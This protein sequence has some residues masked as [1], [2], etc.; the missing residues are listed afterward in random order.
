MEGLT[1]EFIR[2]RMGEPLEAELRKQ[3][4]FQKQQRQLRQVIDD[5]NRGIEMTKERWQAFDQLED[6][7][8]KY[9]YLYGETAYRLGYSDGVL[10]GMEQEADGQTTILS[11]KDMETLIR[12]YDAVEK[13]HYTLFGCIEVH[14]KED[15]I[16]GV[17]DSVTDVIDHGVC[18]EIGLLGEDETYERIVC[19][20]DHDAMTPEERA[21]RLLGKD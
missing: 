1:E 3:D 19:I 9:T 8:S 18:A 7:L 21:R 20:L 17:L 4:N 6:V 2:I 10:A 13:L 11:L 15:G 14:R 5:W 16:L 12:I